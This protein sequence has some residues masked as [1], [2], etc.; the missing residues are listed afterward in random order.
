M[1][2]A[3]P[4][5][6]EVL[7][8][9]VDGLD[10]S[11]EAF[12][13]MSVGGGTIGDA[14]VR[15]FRISF[16]GEL[17]Y[18]VYTSPKYG[19]GVWEAIMDA[20]RSSDIVSYGTEAM[21]V[22]RTE[23]GHV[24]GPELDGRTSAADLGLGRMMSRKKDYIGRRMAARDGIVSND[25]L[26]L[27][28]LKTVRDGETFRMGAHLATDPVTRGPDASQGHVTTS[29]YS[30]TCDQFIGLALLFNGRARTDERLYVTSPLHEELT[31]VV[32]SEPVFVD[33]DGSRMRV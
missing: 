21:T 25:R 22:M 3:G 31:E 6:R 32:V 28:G 8:R 2:V 4:K 15:V 1:A 17:A 30:P 10:L 26:Q 24:A 7:A 9:V 13:F 29:V 12:P 23:K 11:N 18:E 27:V 20:G 33:P 5:S 14:F 19:H 16:S